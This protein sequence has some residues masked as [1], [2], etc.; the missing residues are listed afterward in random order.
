MIKD[1]K[2]A[3]SKAVFGGMDKSNR[4]TPKCAGPYP[5]RLR[6]TQAKHDRRI[7]SQVHDSSYRLLYRMR[8]L[9]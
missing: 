6:M 4:H 3:R 5:A 1:G 2:D 9:R 8:S 7:E